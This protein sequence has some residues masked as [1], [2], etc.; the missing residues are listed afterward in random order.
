M[1]SEDLEV[2]NTNKTVVHYKLLAA[3]A[4]FGLICCFLQAY[5]GYFALYLFFCQIT[6]SCSVERLNQEKDKNNNDNAE[7]VKNHICAFQALQQKHEKLMAKNSKLKAEYT[8]LQPNHQELIAEHNKLAN[9]SKTLH[10]NIKVKSSSKRKVRSDK[11]SP[12]T[13]DIIFFRPCQ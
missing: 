3:S 12:R 5:A 4:C 11:V 7:S 9:E 8:T 1:E 13:V 10:H 2:I 6:L